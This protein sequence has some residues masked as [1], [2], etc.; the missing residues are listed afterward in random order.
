MPAG[1]TPSEKTTWNLCSELF[2]QLDR[3]ASSRIWKK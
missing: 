2:Y 3:R 1:D